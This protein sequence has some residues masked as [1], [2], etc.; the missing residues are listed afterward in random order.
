MFFGVSALVVDLRKPS[1]EIE[2]ALQVLRSR[3]CLRAGAVAR[4]ER[5]TASSGSAR[6]GSRGNGKRDG[7]AQQQAANDR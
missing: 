1:A 2:A 3:E 6:L 4:I 5:R 7:E